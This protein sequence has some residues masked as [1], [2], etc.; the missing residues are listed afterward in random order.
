MFVNENIT[1]SKTYK[2]LIKQKEECLTKKTNS[3]VKDSEIPDE[4][5]DLVFT[6][7][8]YFDQ[9]PFSEYLQLWEFFTNYEINLKDEL[10]QSNRVSFAMNREMYLNYLHQVLS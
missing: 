3:K 8:P 9:I 10:V 5:V 7:P 2:D 4:S 6:D 1:I